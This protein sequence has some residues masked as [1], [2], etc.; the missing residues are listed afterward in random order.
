MNDKLAEEEELHEALLNANDSSAPGLDGLPYG[1]YKTFPSLMRPLARILSLVMDGK[2][3]LP[4][5]MEKDVTIPIYKNKGDRNSAINYRP[6]K[7]INCDAKLGMCLIRDRTLAWILESTCVSMEQMGFIK[8]RKITD[9]LLSVMDALYFS[10]ETASNMAVLNVDWK[11]AYDVVHRGGEEG[12]LYRTL[13]H[14]GMGDRCLALIKAFHDNAQ[15][16]VLINGWLS[17]SFCIKSGVRQGDPSAPLLFLISLQPLLYFLAKHK[18]FRL[19]GAPVPV[20]GPV[21]EKRHIMT[22]NSPL[23]VQAFADDCSFFFTTLLALMYLFLVLK[24]WGWASASSLNAHKSWLLRASPYSITDLP[25]TWTALFIVVSL[26]LRLPAWI[27][28]SPFLLLAWMWWIIC[29]FSGQSCS[30][31]RRLLGLTMTPQGS[32]SLTVLEMTN[33]LESVFKRWSTASLSTAG[34]TYIANS[35]ALSKFWVLYVGP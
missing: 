26:F 8:G 29:S 18:T 25:I 20:V 24:L 1:F 14:H 27:T 2:A 21:Q 6:I 13:R 31:P 11:N 32:S 28:L 23:A 12:W 15:G 7:L 3:A 17:P 4:A 30:N 34:R 16:Q 33:V 10:E 19:T 5:S 35:E 22:S 9:A